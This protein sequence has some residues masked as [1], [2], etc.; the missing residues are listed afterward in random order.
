MSRKYIFC[1]KQRGIVAILCNLCVLFFMVSGCGKL[2]NSFDDNE[3]KDMLCTE[4]YMSIPLK[5]GYSDDQPVLLDSSKIFW[6]N[7][8]R[9]LEQNLVS[10]N[11]AREWGS[12]LIVSDGM[13]KELQNKEEVMH[14]T[15]YLNGK[16]VC[17]RDVLVGA[18]CCHVTYYG[19]GSLTQIIQY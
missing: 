6:V 5:L 1:V 11:E 15:G 13:R 9:Y 19:T 7:K 3:C 10:W 17:E 16:I 18:D 12:Y 2:S 14:F 4:I 8:N